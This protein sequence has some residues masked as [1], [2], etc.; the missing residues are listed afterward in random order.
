MK[1][2]TEEL[3]NAFCIA[4]GTLLALEIALLLFLN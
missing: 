3:L 2:K 4:I 1:S